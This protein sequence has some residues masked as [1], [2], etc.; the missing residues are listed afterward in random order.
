MDGG[1]SEGPEVG[2]QRSGLSQSETRL[3]DEPL[4]SLDGR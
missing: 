4:R 3:R 1:T 2:D